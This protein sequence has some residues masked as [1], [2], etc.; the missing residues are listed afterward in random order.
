V[1]ETVKAIGEIVGG[2]LLAAFLPGLVIVTIGTAIAGIIGGI[3]LAI[4][5]I[6]YAGRAL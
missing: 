3:R 4:W 1:E 5:L 6:E 2:L